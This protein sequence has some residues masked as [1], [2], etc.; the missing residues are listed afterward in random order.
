M[1]RVDMVTSTL[2]KA[3]AAPGG[4]LRPE[5]SCRHAPAAGRPYSSP[6]RWRLRLWRDKAFEMLGH[7]GRRDRLEKNTEHFRTAMTEAGFIRP[8]VR[9]IVPIMLGEARL[10]ATVADAMLERGIYVIEFSYPVDRRDTRSACRYRQPTHLSTSIKRWRPSPQGR[11]SASSH[12]MAPLRCS[13]AVV[14]AVRR[15]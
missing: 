9:P 2:G 8:G 5:G 6:T 7:N 13:G 10:A 11:G 1:G 12:K 4:S 3:P 15:P 14:C